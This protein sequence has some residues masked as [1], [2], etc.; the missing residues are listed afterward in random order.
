MENFNINDI[1]EV[2]SIPKKRERSR[3]ERHNRQKHHIRRR[4]L[5]ETKIGFNQKLLMTIFLFSCFVLFFS[6]LI[7]ILLTIKGI[8]TPKIFIPS[9]TIFILSFIFSGGILGTYVS[10]PSGQNIQM[11]EGDLF[12]MRI[13]SPVIMIVITIIFLLFSLEN[14]KLLKLD[15]KKSQNICELNKGLSMEEIYNKL[16][17]T[18]N[19][20]EQLK[21]NLIYIFN[22]NLVSF[23]KGKCVKLNTEENNYIC[24]TDIKYNTVYLELIILQI[25]NVSNLILTITKR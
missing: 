5:F 3:M 8:L 20:L 15:I 16:N 22:K 24:N 17:K 9:I 7:N 14:I 23:P 2:E 25:L 11:K 4:P 10:P 12:I 13:F 18:K 6:F 1:E 21:Y 19:E